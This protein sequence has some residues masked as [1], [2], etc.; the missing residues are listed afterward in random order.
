[1]PHSLLLSSS[2]LFFHLTLSNQPRN[3]P[4]CLGFPLLTYNK[5][6]KHTHTDTWTVW[7][8]PIISLIPL[9]LCIKHIFPIME[10][11]CSGSPCSDL[12]RRGG[13]KMKADRLAGFIWLRIQG[14]VIFEDAEYKEMCVCVCV[15]LRQG[16]EKR[17]VWKGGEKGPESNQIP[18]IGHY[19][20]T[21][22]D[23]VMW[24]H[25]VRGWEISLF[26]DVGVLKGKRREN[27]A[28]VNTWCMLGK[29]V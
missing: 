1:M 21:L 29:P 28:D 10:M 3:C 9:L 22:S 26:T 25:S 14:C 13:E 16:E 20:T 12:G 15:A 2:P 6:K 7:P 11:T 23:S 24:L 17:S 8:S 27:E 4:A 5:V 19:L 18:L